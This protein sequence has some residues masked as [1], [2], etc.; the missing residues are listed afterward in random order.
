MVLI[1]IFSLFLQM[2]LRGF[3]RE[4]FF[5]LSTLDRDLG[6]EISL[7]LKTRVQIGW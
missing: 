7:L 6:K 4:L 2:L 1:F 5:C 3:G